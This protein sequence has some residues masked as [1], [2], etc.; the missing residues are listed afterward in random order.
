[1]KITFETT[2]NTKRICDENGKFV[3]W[4]SETRSYS[5][6]SENGNDIGFLFSYQGLNVSPNFASVFGYCASK[7][8]LISGIKEFNKEANLFKAFLSEIKATP[9]FS[10]AGF[11][12]EIKDENKIIHIDEFLKR[13]VKSGVLKY[14]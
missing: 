13:K 1:M 14:N 12:V 11:Y 3:K 6:D 8:E 10:K 2:Q 9:C 4:E 5:L 7:E